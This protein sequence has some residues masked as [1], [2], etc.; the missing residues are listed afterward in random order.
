MSLP[1][2]A[3]VYARWH[4][5]NCGFELD[6]DINHGNPRSENGILFHATFI[7]LLY[8]KKTYSQEALRYFYQDIMRQSTEKSGVFNRDATS[9]DVPYKDRNE[10]SKDNYIGISSGSY[11]CGYSTICKLIAKHGISNFGIYNNVKPRFSLP[12]N[13][14]SMFIL[15]AFANYDFLCLFFYPIYVINLLI[16][17]NKTKKETSGKILDLL[18][19]PNLKHKYYI[20]PLYNYYV[21]KMTKTYGENFVEELMKI[22]YNNP[23]HPNRLYAKGIILKEVK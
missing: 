21:R 2:L 23:Q 22:Y 6:P 8:L 11:V 14:G 4:N 1:S 12:M 18:I 17:S 16:S 15:L 13:P 10:N 9:K 7:N 20:K 19:L 5:P 3:E